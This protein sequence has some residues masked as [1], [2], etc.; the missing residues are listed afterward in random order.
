M[1]EENNVEKAF[2]NLLETILDILE[3][4]DRKDTLARLIKILEEIQNEQQ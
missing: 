1:S 4:E 2:I 3:P